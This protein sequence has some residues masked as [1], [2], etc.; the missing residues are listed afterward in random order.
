MIL[1]VAG[2]NN[3]YYNNNNQKTAAGLQKPNQPTNLYW[4]KPYFVTKTQ[5]NLANSYF[6]SSGK[7]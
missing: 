1:G 4:Q 7:Q 5:Q 3:L 2:Y 6:I